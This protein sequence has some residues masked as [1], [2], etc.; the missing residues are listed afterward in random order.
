MSLGLPR[1][2]QPIL[3]A[4]DK[5]ELRQLRES[6]VSVKEAAAYKGISRATALRALADL[7]KKL[8]PEKLP[9]GRRA[10]SY[11]GRLENPLQQ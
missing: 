9:N 2:R 4:R 5:F 8:G 7:R 6:G 11:L 3:S 10:R 1:G